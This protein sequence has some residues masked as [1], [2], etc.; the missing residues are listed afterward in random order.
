[1]IN[2]SNDSLKRI[3]LIGISIEA[4]KLRGY[5]IVENGEPEKQLLILDERFGNGIGANK[6]RAKL[7]LAMIARDGGSKHEIS[8]LM[9]VLFNLKMEEQGHKFL[10]KF[11]LSERSLL[12]YEEAKYA[13]EFGA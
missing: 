11:G 2:L 10:K 1:M 12:E 8:K 6:E 7:A 3:G 13:A 9:R 4:L 5:Q